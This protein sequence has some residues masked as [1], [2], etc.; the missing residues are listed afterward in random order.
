MHLNFQLVPLKVLYHLYF[1]LHVDAQSEEL[2]KLKLEQ[3]GLLT[4]SQSLEKDFL[5]LVGTQEKLKDARNR[6]QT[7][8]LSTKIYDAHQKVVSNANEIEKI[9]K[10]LQSIKLELTKLRK[11]LQIRVAD[12]NNL[13]E[14][15][16]EP[17]MNVCI[18]RH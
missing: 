1:I 7:N 2:S 6:K 8:R 14:E 16:H 17:D 5:E 15:V 3:H 10:N 9:S 18:C 12:K 4:E 11:A 13:A